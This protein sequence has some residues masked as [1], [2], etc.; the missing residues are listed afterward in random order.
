MPLFCKASRNKL[1]IFQ[2][3]EGFKMDNKGYIL[4]NLSFDKIHIF[5]IQHRK[6]NK[7]S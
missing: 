2:N 1:K 4:Q 7:K 6:L 5:Y 3:I